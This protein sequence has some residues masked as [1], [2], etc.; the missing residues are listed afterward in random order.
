ME[1]P[2]TEVPDGTV[3]TPRGFLAGATDARIRDDYAQGRL[4][5]AL[6]HSER[7][8][9]AAAVYTR[10]SFL[11]PPLRV[12]RAN[13]ADAKAQAVIANSGIANCLTGDPGVAD[14]QEMARLAAE[15][16][17]LAPEDVAVA[18]TGVTGWRLPMDRIREAMRHILP[19]TDGGDAFAH[20]IM[21]T[22]TVAKQ[23]AVQFEHDGVLYSVGGC[24]K[25]SGMI[26]PNM[27]TMLSFLTTDAAVEPRFLQSVLSDAVEVSYNMMTIDGDTSP[28]DLVLLLA[29]G[30]A[31]NGAGAIDEHHDAAPVFRAAVEHVAIALA[32]KLARDG[33]GA[34]KLI[35]VR[36]DGA[37]SL[38]DARLAAKEVA[39]SSLVKTAVYGN[40]PNWGR[41]LVAAGNSGA[42]ILE[43]KVSL[44]IQDTEV[45]RNGEPLPFDEAAVSNAL[46]QPEVRFR[47]DLGLGD[48]TATAWGCDLTPDYVRINAEYTT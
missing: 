28:E 30:A 3:T 2:L 11:G 48:A 29:N 25:G 31:A 4:D 14:A 1:A 5:L 27:A 45:Y 8:C 47:I 39:G 10:N 43:E 6:L 42:Q 7:P 18:S 16:L 19:T 23:A 9:D 32:R 22:D 21:T 26:H 38:A 44:A 33:E 17:G 12:T 13:L 41:I 35:E 40:D 20:A 46:R 36:V 24:A 15:K 37:A 34:S